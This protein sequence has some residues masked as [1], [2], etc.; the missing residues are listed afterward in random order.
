MGNDFSFDF[1]NGG[2]L[3]ENTGGKKKKKIMR[4][5]RMVEAVKVF[6]QKKL[7]PASQ[8]SQLKKK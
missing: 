4:K 1:V 7:S 3:I 2:R 5:K 8:R 6:T